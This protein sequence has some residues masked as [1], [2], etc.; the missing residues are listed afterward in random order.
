MLPESR[1]R[2]AIVVPPGSVPRQNSASDFDRVCAATAVRALAVTHTPVAA[3]LV[4]KLVRDLA[5]S[6]DNRYEMYPVAEVQRTL[7]VLLVLGIGDVAG[8]G[9]IRGSCCW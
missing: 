5:L 8:E 7:A 9:G 6:A 1:H 4:P 3:R 2:V